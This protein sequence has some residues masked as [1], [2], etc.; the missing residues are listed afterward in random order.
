MEMEDV[1][2]VGRWLRAGLGRY[3]ERGGVAK[4]R[5]IEG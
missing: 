4:N 2:N 1:E 5:G 3:W